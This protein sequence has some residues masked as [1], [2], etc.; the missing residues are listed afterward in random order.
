MC[1]KLKAPTTRT[2][3]CFL[4][5]SISNFG[6]VFFDLKDKSKCLFMQSEIKAKADRKYSIQESDYPSRL[7][8]PK[9]VDLGHQI[10]NRKIT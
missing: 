10:S 8:R 2:A 3:D 7:F 5:S 9:P 4:R 6:F 1:L